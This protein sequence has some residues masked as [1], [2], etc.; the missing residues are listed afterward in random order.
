MLPEL[1]VAIFST[2]V[3]L[4]GIKL[5]QKGAYL[6]LQG[7]KTKAVIFKNNF[8]RSGNSDGLYHPVVRF[9]TDDKEWVTQELNVG[10]LPA[11]PE[12]TKL[13]VIYDPGEPTN[14]K[15]NSSF[16]LEILPCLL[17]FTGAI[18]FILSVLYYAGVI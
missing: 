8:K 11:K 12:G 13:E 3:V 17:I 1:L 7:K 4:V 5:Y 18:G 16:Q 6:K 9:T 15:I 10:Y 14:V 2:L